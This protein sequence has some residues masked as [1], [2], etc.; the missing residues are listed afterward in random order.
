M[1]CHEGCT[2]L[3]KTTRRNKKKLDLLR[4]LF[5]FLDAESQV[6]WDPWIFITFDKPVPHFFLPS[7]EL[8]ILGLLAAGNTA[9]L[10]SKVPADC[11]CHL[12]VG[13]RWHRCSA[14]VL[15]MFWKPASWTSRPVHSVD[16]FRVSNWCSDTEQ[17]PSASP[18]LLEWCM[19]WATPRSSHTPPGFRSNFRVVLD[20]SFVVY[21]VWIFRFIFHF[22][23][24]SEVFSWSSLIRSPFG[25]HLSE[26]QQDQTTSR[27][28]KCFNRNSVP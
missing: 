11:C 7:P 15:S 24:E 4:K 18:W 10:R 12:C 27:D 14:A 16:D 8:R 1:T 28:W 21:L 3:L 20:R 25:W 17:K 22:L 9:S 26:H 6:F 19:W 2:H 13:H 5:S 23:N